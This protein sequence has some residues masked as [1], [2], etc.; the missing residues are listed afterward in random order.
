[1]IFYMIF[2]MFMTTSSSFHRFITNQF[3]V[4]LPVGLLAQLVERCT[5]IAEVKGLNPLQAWM[6]SGFLFAT[7]KSCVYNCDNHLS[8]KLKLTR[9]KTAT[10][11]YLAPAVQKKD[12]VVHRINFYLLDIA[13]GFPNTDLSNGQWFIWP[14]LLKSW[15]AL[16]NG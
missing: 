6:F 14:Q 5:S 15:I 16:S 12:N 11:V 10:A 7:A 1:M 9:L 4:L 3:N 2:H 13:I 8:V